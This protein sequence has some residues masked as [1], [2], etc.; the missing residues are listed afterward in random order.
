MVRKTRSPAAPNLPLVG[1]RAVTTACVVRRAKQIHRAAVLGSLHR[2]A[3]VCGATSGGP[4]DGRRSDQHGGATST[5]GQLESGSTPLT[6]GDSRMLHAVNEPTRPTNRA[7]LVARGSQA[8][9]A[10]SAG[11]QSGHRRPLHQY[12]TRLIHRSTE[13]Q[14]RMHTGSTTARPTLYLAW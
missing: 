11:L 12:R 4:D 10:A 8:K 1:T 5:A 14:S 3:G 6:V 2:N 7:H 9:V 13:K